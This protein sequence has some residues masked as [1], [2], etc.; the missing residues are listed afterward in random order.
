MNA[1]SL[2]MAGHDALQV[3]LDGLSRDA[4]VSDLVYVPLE[5][6]LLAQA[7]RIGCQTVDGLGMLLFQA[8]PGFERW[9]GIAPHVDDQ[10]RQAVLS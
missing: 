8:A 6:E 9:F 7:R 1:T 2:G 10:L 4:V 5:T 3:P